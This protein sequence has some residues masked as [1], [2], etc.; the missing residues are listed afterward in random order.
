M[1]IFDGDLGRAADVETRGTGFR[2]N[3]N[4]KSRPGSQ[5][6]LFQG[7]K[8]VAQHRWPRGYSPMRMASVSTM[9]G[10]GTSS[11]PRRM[12]V[13]AHPEAGM[14]S[15]VTLSH[16]HFNPFS[17]AHTERLMLEPI[18]RSTLPLSSVASLHGG[19]HMRIDPSTTPGEHA[20]YSPINRAINVNRQ[21]MLSVEDPRQKIA[22]ADST[23]I[24][25][26][27][28]HE[29]INARAHE[30]AQRVQ[31]H[32]AGHEQ[33][34]EA[35]RGELEHHADAGM[36]KHF[37]NDPRNQRKTGFDVRKAT[38]GGRGNANLAGHG[39][40]DPG[41]ETGAETR[42]RLFA[43]K[44]EHHRAKTGEVASESPLHPGQFNRQLAMF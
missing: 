1:T 26:F 15:D 3:T 17:Q 36:I 7:G 42:A 9:L 38:Y 8:P 41:A 31:E 12:T 13:T 18:A 29:D 22:M 43:R 23:L 37:R 19:V 14:G 40:S 24:H 44:I 6:T 20:H 21:P 27:G 25:E 11:S 33:G 5:G 39:Y 2:M 35:Q 10:E 34:F 30:I 28:H 32:P 4:I 16:P